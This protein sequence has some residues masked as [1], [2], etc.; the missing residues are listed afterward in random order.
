MDLIIYYSM[1]GFMFFSGI[2]LFFNLKYKKKVEKLRK[3]VKKM[4]KTISDR[5]N[6]IFHL[7]TTLNI[8]STAKAA[9]KKWDQKEMKERLE[10][11]P[12]IRRVK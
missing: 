5:E 8:M 9:H 4:E 1:L 6:R 10:S 12:Y 3:D 7:E 11:H 2:L